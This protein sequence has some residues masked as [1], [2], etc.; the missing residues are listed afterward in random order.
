MIKNVTIEQV[1]VSDRSKE[2][3]PFIGRN[4]KPFK[5]VAIKVGD[6][7]FSGF[8]NY[9]TETYQA[10]DTVMI[11]VSEREYN[12]KIYYDFKPAGKLELL[13]MRIEKLEELV[14]KLG[15]VTNEVKQDVPEDE[16]PF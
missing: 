4:G 16:I 2:G 12:G 13:E 14:K 7:W 10:G 9:I 5:K 6:Q 3:K 8:G 11:E 15:Y 1:F